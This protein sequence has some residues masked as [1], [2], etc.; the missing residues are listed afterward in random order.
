MWILSFTLTCDPSAMGTTP[1]KTEPVSPS[2]L[3]IVAAVTACAIAM[4]AV[5][6]INLSSIAPTIP[7]T[8][9]WWSA[10]GVIVVTFGLMIRFVHR[11]AASMEDRGW[12]E[13]IWVPVQAW[14]LFNAFVPRGLNKMTGL[15][16]D[17]VDVIAVLALAALL[18]WWGVLCCWWFKHAMASGRSEVEEYKRKRAH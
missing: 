18:A 5:E 12:F 15:K 6:V 10:L 3:Q 9:I 11:R 1:V 7:V 8:L 4:I 14:L 16:Q 2:R 13:L 17:A